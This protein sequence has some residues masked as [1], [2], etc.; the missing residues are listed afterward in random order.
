MFENVDAHFKQTLFLCLHL[1]INLIDIYTIYS[2][3]YHALIETHNTGL[4]I[5][6]IDFPQFM[7]CSDAS[8]EDYLQR[9]SW[10][11]IHAFSL[12]L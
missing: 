10:F 12:E 9:Y 4:S 3:N 1:G 7:I 8:A 11:N 5:Y 6:F 2:V